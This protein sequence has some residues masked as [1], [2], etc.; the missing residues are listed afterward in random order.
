LRHGRLRRGALR[1]QALRAH[2]RAR[3]V[4]VQCKKLHRQNGGDG[5]GLR[6][7]GEFYLFERH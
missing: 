5:H 7:T 4:A 3:I 1:T 2:L 6:L